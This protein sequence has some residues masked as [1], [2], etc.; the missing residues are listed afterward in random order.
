MWGLR[1]SL[2]CAQGLGEEGLWGCWSLRPR[3]WGGARVGPVGSQPPTRLPSALAPEPGGVRADLG[4]VLQV[5][6]GSRLF[7]APQ[8]AIAEKRNCQFSW[9]ESP[10][11]VNKGRWLRPGASCA[12]RCGPQ[13]KRV[14]L[15]Q[16]TGTL[17]LNCRRTFKKIV[18]KRLVCRHHF[19]LVLNLKP[20]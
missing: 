15:R 1:T 8:N 6:G 20:S 5:L 3:E 7:S 9:R 11:P 4:G 2:A 17:V 12:G 10:R 14:C 16:N 19:N 18:H 13:G